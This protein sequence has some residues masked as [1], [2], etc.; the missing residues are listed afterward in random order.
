MFSRNRAEFITNSDWSQNL[1]EEIR[2]S[3]GTHA[4]GRA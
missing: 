3:N 1:A 4:N 2:N